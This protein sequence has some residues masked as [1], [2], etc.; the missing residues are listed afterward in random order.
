MMIYDEYCT[1][2]WGRF[3]IQLLIKISCDVEGDRE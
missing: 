2:I 1:V 3:N